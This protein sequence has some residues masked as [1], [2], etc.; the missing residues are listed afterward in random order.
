MLQKWQE[1]LF[2]SDNARETIAKNRSAQLEK[3]ELIQKRKWLEITYK[4]CERLLRNSF[5][6]TYAVL[7]LHT[8][9]CRPPGGV[10][11]LPP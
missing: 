2:V 8:H 1:H 9:K 5:N 7:L 11:G 10:Q 3:S 4:K 6:V